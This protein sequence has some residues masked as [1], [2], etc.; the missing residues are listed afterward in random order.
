MHVGK[1]FK[2]EAIDKYTVKFSFAAPYP[3]F[4]YLFGTSYVQP[5]QPKHF[6]KKYHI[7][8][9]PNANE[10]AKEHGF[11]NWV[12][13][14]SQFYPSSDWKDVPTPMLKG[15]FDFSSPTLEA[16]IVVKDT[17]TGRFLVPNPYFHQ[18]DTVGNQL[19]YISEID[20]TYIPDLEVWKLRITRGEIDYK[21]QGMLL[22]DYPVFKEN[23]E[24]GN[25]KVYLPPAPGNNQYYSFNTTVK[26][27][28]LRKIF[29]DI[30]FLKAMSLAINRDELNELIYLGQG[31]PEQYVPF[32][33]LTTKVPTE[34]DL[35]YYIQYDPEQ[36]KKLL[37][38]VGLKDID[39][40][41]FREL[42]S[43]KKL[44]IRFFYCTQ[45]QSPKMHELVRDY[46]AKVGI[47]MV[48]KEVSSD[49]FRAMSNNNEGE[50]TSWGSSE[51]LP[52]H[53]LTN[54]WAI[55]PPFGD[56]FVP[57]TGFG[58]AQWMNTNGKEGVEPPEDVKRL[59]EL[60][61]ELR[62]YPLG[63]PE[64]TRIAREIIDIH[65][66]HL[67]KIGTVGQ[68]PLPQIASNRIGNFKPFNIWT[69]YYWAY[70]YRPTQWYLKE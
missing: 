43:G 45:E 70:A 18:I 26:D 57:G 39:G 25:Y 68:I 13:L 49:Q 53:I 56:F 51:N 54:G 58:W 16:F 6:L 34:E 9:N 1:P 62:K 50:I 20:E 36:A 12:E 67:F 37:D 8:Y 19:P 60:R 65:L 21:T 40:D 15:T 14:I 10:L 55:V 7:K 59:F 24:V 30:R 61:D 11:S 52:W 22:E 41:G 32:D 48:L 44:V 5:F 66:K 23:E 4:L 64:S 28:E 47:R 33:P 31:K 38:E 2:V 69:G 42:P 63:T 17:P 35:N 46:W 3:G 29:N 27:L